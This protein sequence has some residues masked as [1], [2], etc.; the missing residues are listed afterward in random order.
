L[1]HDGTIE[2]V[3][4]RAAVRQ[5]AIVDLVVLGPFAVPLSHRLTCLLVVDR[6]LLGGAGFAALAPTACCSRRSWV[7]LLR[8]HRRCVF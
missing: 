6:H 8:S 2:N 1:L 3:G 5:A 7:P 4:A